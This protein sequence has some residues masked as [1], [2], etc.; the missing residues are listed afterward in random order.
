MFSSSA[1]RAIFEMERI[2]AFALYIWCV[3]S[4]DSHMSQ[5]LIS[6]IVPAYKVEKWL[7]SC[8]RSICAQSYRHLEIICVDDGSP[9]E[10][11]SILDALAAE[12]SRIKVIHQK[13]QGLS[14]ARNAALAVASGEWVTGVDG[15]DTLA[16]GVYEAAVAHLTSD[17]DVLVFGTQY[18]DESGSYVDSPN[19]RYF[20]LPGQGCYPLEPRLCASV[21]VCFCTKLWRR[22]IIAAHRLEFPVGMLHEDEAF[23]RLFY[24]YAAGS[25][26]VLP[27]VGYL[28][29]ERAG[30]IMAEKSKAQKEVGVRRFLDLAVW[31]QRE[32]EQRCLA[33]PH[34][35]HIISLLW[36]AA[37]HISVSDVEMRRRLGA[38]LET[39]ETHIAP[40]H[41]YRLRYMHRLV[42][43]QLSF[44]FRRMTWACEE[45]RVLGVPMVRIYYQ[46]GCF[47]RMET[48]L[49][50]SARALCGVWRRWR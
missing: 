20:E 31:L 26:Y 30:S 32:W 45:Y 24:A 5:P 18:V 41:D 23:A 1:A 21:N 33:A 40:A 27:Q 50:L 13:N 49:R 28:Y 46:N 22:S 25:M 44:P 35:L 11:G 4:Y 6:V 47:D 8:V 43:G 42:Q 36:L 38:M 14:A 3:L 12:D 15:D 10:C 37:A 16:P 9:D 34:W 17:V 19:S 48:I 39:C 29:L 7:E 2:P